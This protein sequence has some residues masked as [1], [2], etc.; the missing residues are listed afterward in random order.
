MHLHNLKNNKKNNVHVTRENLFAGLHFP[1]RIDRCIEV[2][3]GLANQFISETSILLDLARN[4]AS[5]YVSCEA[6]N[7]TDICAYL[8]QL[9][10][11]AQE[12]AKYYV[13]KLR[14][15]NM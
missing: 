1:E 15:I 12:T 13:E 2:V 14:L 6:E 9:D 10:I 3:E 4:D 7:D 8:A 5:A 11:E